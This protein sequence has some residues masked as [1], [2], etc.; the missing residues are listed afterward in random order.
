MAFKLG[1]G[2]LSLTLQLAPQASA[3][4][5]VIERAFENPSAP[6]EGS[7]FYRLRVWVR[8]MFCDLRDN[9]SWIYHLSEL[10]KHRAD[11]PYRE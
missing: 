8:R 1:D 7:P 2:Q 6:A 3:T 9:N 4:I 10:F 11:K 5:H